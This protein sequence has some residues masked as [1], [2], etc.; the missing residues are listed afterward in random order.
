MLAF[1]EGKLLLKLPQKRPCAKNVFHQKQNLITGVKILTV[2]HKLSKFQEIWCTRVGQHE[3]F[4]TWMFSNFVSSN[5]IS[6]HDF[7][8]T[9]CMLGRYARSK[10]SVA[11]E[12]SVGHDFGHALLVEQNKPTPWFLCSTTRAFGSLVHHLASIYCGF[13]HISL[14]FHSCSLVSHSCSLVFHSCSPVFIRVH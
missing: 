7:K 4:K 10:R 14:V 6:L 12:I 1:L 13:Y 5:A 8:L 11:T 3:I 9:L 2:L